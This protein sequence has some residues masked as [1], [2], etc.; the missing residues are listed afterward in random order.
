MHTEYYTHHTIY[1]KTKTVLLNTFTST[2]TTTEQILQNYISVF[3][4]LQTV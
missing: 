2:N 4:R 3:W 1:T